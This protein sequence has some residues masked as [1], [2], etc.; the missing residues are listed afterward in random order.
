METCDENG[1]EI[2]MEAVD[3][4]DLDPEVCCGLL[5]SQIGY[6]WAYCPFCGAPFDRW[7]ILG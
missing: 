3:Q 6:E 1:N 5:L 4:T 2:T 7:V